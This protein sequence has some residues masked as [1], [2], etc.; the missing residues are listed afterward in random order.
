VQNAHRID[1][2][3]YPEAD[4][5]DA[6][7]L[8]LERGTEADALRD[9]IRLCAGGEGAQDAAGGALPGAAAG[10]VQVLSPMKRGVLGCVN[11]NRELQ[12]ALNP[13]AP[14]KVERRYGDRVFREG[15][16]VMQTR[17]NYALE[18]TDAEYG[19]E[20]R[21]VFN[22][23]IG[24]VKD[25]DEGSGVVTV[26]YDDTRYVSYAAD[27]LMEIEHAYAITV[28]KSQGSEFPAVVIPLYKVAPQLMTRN[29]IY[30]AVTRGKEG[31][32]L[33]GS[34]EV[35]RRMIDNDRGLTRYSGLK[36]F[37]IEYAEEGGR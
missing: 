16:R 17:N 26:A 33:V 11:L 6:D 28:H 24:V 2:G 29:L 15:D 12:E 31:V 21:G 22:G 35:L 25:I 23:D 30:T 8:M 1:R 34:M 13:P 18:W 7:F 5:K 14:F 37:L 3:E 4:E 9:V 10:G 20:G 19:E 27:A 36:S 32:A